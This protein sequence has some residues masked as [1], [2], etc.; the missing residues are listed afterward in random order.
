MSSETA[1]HKFVRKLGLW[2]AIAISVGCIIGSG[3]F[4]VPSSVATHLSSSSL[5]LSVWVV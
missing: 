5:I 3:I 4:R 1:P 2:D